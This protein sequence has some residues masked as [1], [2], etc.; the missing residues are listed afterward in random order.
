MGRAQPLPDGSAMNGR[1]PRGS[2]EWQF[3]VGLKAA[4]G[5]M[6]SFCWAVQIIYN[7]SVL[8]AV[9]VRPRRAHWHAGDGQD[10][11]DHHAVRAL[12]AWRGS[13]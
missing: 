6:F 7:W 10:V 8:L 9:C 5:L 13:W 4:T 2:G 1:G 3:L 11:L 12:W